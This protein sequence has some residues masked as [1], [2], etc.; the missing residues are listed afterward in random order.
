MP[1][2]ASKWQ[3][4]EILEAVFDQLSDALFLYDKA[5]HIVGVQKR[6]CSTWPTKASHGGLFRAVY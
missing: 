5:L 1:T 6:G 4:P 3:R 2:L